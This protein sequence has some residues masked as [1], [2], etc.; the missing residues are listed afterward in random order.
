MVRRTWDDRITLA[1]VK[2]R[3][4]IGVTREERESPQDCEVELTVWSSFEAAAAADSIDRSIDYCQLLE[5]VQE[6]AGAC[7]Y[8]LVETLAYRIARKILQDFPV[9][10]ARVKLRKWPASLRE[11][12]DFVEVEVEES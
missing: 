11:Q 12:I 7:E 8:N 2:L 9:N 4:R 5:A 1:G 10:R 3:P 6:I